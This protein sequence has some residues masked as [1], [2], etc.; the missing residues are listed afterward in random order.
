MYSTDYDEDFFISSSARPFES[1]GIMS[2]SSQFFP[3]MALKVGAVMPRDSL[4][5]ASDT[6]PPPLAHTRTPSLDFTTPDSGVED[7]TPGSTAADDEYKK[8]PTDLSANQ[9]WR[10]L[11]SGSSSE[12]VSPSS[13]AAES[14]GGLRHTRDKLK[15]DLP[16]SPHIP[17][18]RH[19]RVFNFSLEKPKSRRALPEH[20][21]EMSPLVMTDETPVISTP[22]PVE[23]EDLPILEP[24][25]STFGKTIAKTIEPEKAIVFDEVQESA[26]DDARLDSEGD[27]LKG[28]SGKGEGAAADSADE[29]SGIESSAKAT[30]ERDSTNLA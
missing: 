5:D 13:P 19:N 24:T 20:K 10:S 12:S 27:K 11:D 25:F 30:L 28:E 22:L 15:L 14:L 29:D 1:L 17:S 3:G 9:C 6:Y 16:P 4:T 18:P 23:C 2:T 21:P 8:P 26:A 7:I